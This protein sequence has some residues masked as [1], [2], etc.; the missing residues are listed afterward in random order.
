MYKVFRDPE[1]E[2]CLDQ[3]SYKTEPDGRTS[4]QYSEDDYKKRIQNLNLE[5]K[6]LN[7]RLEKVPNF[8]RCLWYKNKCHSF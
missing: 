5:I 3:H 6:G 1:G 7:E 4:H 2:H 8:I